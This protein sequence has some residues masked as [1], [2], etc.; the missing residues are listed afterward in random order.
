MT[1][2]GWYGRPCGRRSDGRRLRKAALCPPVCRAATMGLL[3]ICVHI[4]PHDG[5]DG[6]T[7][8]RGGAIAWEVADYAQQ[9]RTLQLYLEAMLLPHGLHRCI[10]DWL[11]CLDGTA[12][13]NW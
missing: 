10:E 3:E 11:D 4:R 8:M 9:R 5:T 6:W 1:F 12:A 7:C 2:L 13:A